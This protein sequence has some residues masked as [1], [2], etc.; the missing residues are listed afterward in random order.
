MVDPATQLDQ[1]GNPLQEGVWANIDGG[2]Q[3]KYKR[4]ES[5]ASVHAADAPRG[6]FDMR[7]DPYP[8]P[9]GGQGQFYKCPNCGGQM[10][11]EDGECYR[12]GYTYPYD[13]GEVLHGH[14]D[15]TAWARDMGVPVAPGGLGPVRQG[16][17]AGM[18]MEPSGIEPQHHGTAQPA[19]PAGIHNGNLHW[20]HFLDASI[21]GKPV[22]AHHMELF[23]EHGFRN[24]SRPDP[25]NPG[26][27][28]YDQPNPSWL[29]PVTVSVHHPEHLA[30]AIEAVQTPQLN[31]SKE[32]LAHAPTL[33]A[34]ASISALSDLV[35]D[36]TALGPI[37]GSASIFAQSSVFA[38]PPGRPVHGYAIIRSWSWLK[39]DQ[40]KVH[41]GTM[42][43]TGRGYVKATGKTVGTYAEIQALSNLVATPTVLNPG[44][45]LRRRV[46][47][48]RGG[49]RSSQVRGGVR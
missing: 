1:G 24:H 36:G 4:D 20:L 16:K 45:Q 13:G 21:N 26:K 25:E 3:P 44:G 49:I 10:S 8:L 46:Y 34:S 2:W 6:P 5:F 40:S 35:A 37:L 39:A 47:P 18:Y 38:A 15:P 19:E 42:Y 7:S 17:L 14:D 11:E 33:K 22:R 23:Q 9:S 30:A 32:S 29:A 48:G 12:C 31:A 27:V 43:V 28:I 41:H